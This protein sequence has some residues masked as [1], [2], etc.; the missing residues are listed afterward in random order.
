[1][2]YSAARK[3]CDS[4]TEVYSDVVNKSQIYELNLQAREIQQCHKIL[5][6][7]EVG[8]VEAR[9]LKKFSSGSQ[10]RMPNTTNKQGKKD[11]Y[12]SFFQSQ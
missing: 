8:V 4:V 1:M 2:R 5:P 12:F 3:L 9:S 7:F 6:L 11:E 10:P